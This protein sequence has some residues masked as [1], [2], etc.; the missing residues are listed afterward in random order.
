LNTRRTFSLFHRKRTELIRRPSSSL[1]LKH[2]DCMLTMDIFCDLEP[3]AMAAFEQQTEMWE[4]VAKVLDDF[5]R[6][7]LVELGRGRVTLRDVAGLQSR[8]EE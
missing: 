4:S 6:D 2:R 7:G 1:S 5:Q 3:E 8:M